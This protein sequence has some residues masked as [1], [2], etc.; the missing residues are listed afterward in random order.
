MI[1]RIS[2]DVISVN[3]IRYGI[4][5]MNYNDLR[6]EFFKGKRK[7]ESPRN[8]I[9]R[10]TLT[11]KQPNRYGSA[12][13]TVTYNNMV[14]YADENGKCY[15]VGYDYFGSQPLVFGRIR[16]YFSGCIGLDGVLIK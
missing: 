5:P 6:T 4:F 1:K 14:F 12:A 16:A 3:F 10:C 15:L 7:A 2:E 11:L 9:G 8:Y 13:M